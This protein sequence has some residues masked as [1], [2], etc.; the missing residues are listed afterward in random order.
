MQPPP[1][2]VLVHSLPTNR[3]ATSCHCTAQASL[4]PWPP[5]GLNLA[6]RP[7]S[8]AQRP[9][10]LTRRADRRVWAVGCRQRSLVAIVQLSVHH[11]GACPRSN[12]SVWPS[13]ASLAGR[14]RQWAAP[15]ARGEPS[16]LLGG[17]GRSWPAHRP[18]SGPCWT[19]PAD[20]CITAPGLASGEPPARHRHSVR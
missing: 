16:Y 4:L 14:Y 6:H 3:A 1:S 20:P 19:R 18:L 15:A 12:S 8:T 10:G 2:S 11:S 9:R 17:R 5:S 13:T 7:S